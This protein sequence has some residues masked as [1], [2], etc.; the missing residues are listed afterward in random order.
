MF[1]DEILILDVTDKPSTKEKPAASEEQLTAD[2][3]QPVASEEQ[4]IAGKEQSKANE[5]QLTAGKEQPKASEEQ[6]TLAAGCGEQLTAAGG[7][8][9]LKKGS[10][11]ILG[12][13]LMG[14]GIGE[15]ESEV[16]LAGEVVH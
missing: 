12:E 8:E 1:Y 14:E 13:A 9:Q 16:T 2:K 6:L 4:L 11:D 15:G 7:E 3:E 5:E 10:C